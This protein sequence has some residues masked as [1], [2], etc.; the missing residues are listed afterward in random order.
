[1]RRDRAAV[2]KRNKP[3]APPLGNPPE[4][5]RNAMSLVRRHLRKC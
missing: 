1:M 3:V 4:A 2:R 5:A